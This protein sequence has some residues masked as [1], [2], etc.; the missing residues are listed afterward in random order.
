[1]K[2]NVPFY[3]QTTPFNCGPVNLLMVLKFL[4]INTSLKTLERKMRIKKDRG[5][6][7]IQIANAAKDYD[8]FV[9]L[10][11]IDKGNFEDLAYYQNRT[12]EEKDTISKLHKNVQQKGVHYFK[13]SLSNKEI[14]AKT[15]KNSLPIVLVNWNIIKKVKGYQGHFITLTGFDNTYVYFHNSGLCEGDIP[16]QRIDHKTFKRARKSHGTDEDVL[17]IKKK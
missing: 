9:E 7:T 1:M 5:V 3:K 2:L 14:F 10:Y 4:G 8:V 16:N 11:S 12:K 13:K 17:I 6:Y 15:N